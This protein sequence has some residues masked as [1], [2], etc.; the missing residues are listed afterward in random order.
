M[1]G[2]IARMNLKIVLLIMMLLALSWTSTGTDCLYL[3]NGSR[4]QV[5]NLDA[6]SK[7]PGHNAQFARYGFASPSMPQPMA[8]SS[9]VMITQAKK[10]ME[11]AC[12]AR[13]E[14][15]SARDEAKAANDEAKALLT[16][17]EENEKNIK[18][19]LNDVEA[20]AAKAARAE[21]LFNKTDEAYRKTLALS[22]EVEGNMSQMKSLLEQAKSYAD[23]SAE[24]ADQASENLNRTSL[25]RNQTAVIF[26]QSTSVYSNMTL[27]EKEVQSNSD[28]IRTWM[29]ER[30]P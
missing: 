7:L 18:S 23:S 20:S 28:N 21:V 27:L 10:L 2:V 17:I 24:S 3:G 29:N 11:E 26:G 14:S 15:V 22:V 13:N 9:N 4:H 6:G 12:T 30:I 25:L 8:L 19:L 1:S 16:K 5:I